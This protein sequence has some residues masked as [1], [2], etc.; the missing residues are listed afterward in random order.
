[1]PPG[2]HEDMEHLIVKWLQGRTNSEEDRHLRGWRE[3]SAEN[4]R[5]FTATVRL[6]ELTEH[7]RPADPVRRIPRIRARR[8]QVAWRAVAA[9]ALVLLG[10]GIVHLWWTRAPLRVL[11]FATGPAEMVTATL[12]DGSLVRLGPNS[13]LRFVPSRDRR[14]VSVDGQAFFAVSEDAR[15]PFVVNTRIGAATVL[16]T[17]FDVR[18]D[19]DKLRLIVVEGTVRVAASDVAVEVQDGEMG[20]VRQGGTPTVIP[21]DDVYSYLSWMDGTVVFQSTPLEEAIEEI[22][23]RFDRPIE[24]AD[25]TLGYRQVTAW[26]TNRPF[27]EIVNTLC[28][29]VEAT[30]TV[31]STHATIGR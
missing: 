3:E 20:S 7:A 2:R 13:R 18:V 12:S 25:T 28:R 5:A 17:R 23:R 22:E 29:V 11:E 26:F 21:V 19:A 8:Q 14:T 1:M 9:A 31:D 27:E 24:L 4:E 16:G 6:W 15:R 10:L 30:C